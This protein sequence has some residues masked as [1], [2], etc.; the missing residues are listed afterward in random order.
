LEDIP[1]ATVIDPNQITPA[2][3]PASQTSA[4]VAAGGAGVAGTKAPATPGQNVPQQP[5]AQ[6]S[7]YLGA[8]QPQTNQFA[9]Q[10]A[11]DVGGKVNA[12]G[13]AINP[14]VN[15]YTGNL[16]TVPTDTATN[17]AVSTAPSTLTPEQTQSFNTELQAGNNA[18]NSANTFETTSPYQ[19]LTTNIQ[20]AVEQANLWNSG[21]NPANLSTALQPYEAPTATQGDTTLDALLLSG[22]PGAYS[23]IQN[24]VAPAANLQNQLAAGTTQADTSLQNAIAQDQS[25]TAAATAAPQTYANNLTSYLQNAVNQATQGDTAQNAQILQDLQNNTP[26]PADLQTLGVTADQWAT[27]SSQMAADTTAPINLASYLTQT[28]PNATAQNIAT[29]TQYADVAALQNILGGNAPVEPITSATANEAGTALTPSQLNSLNIGQAEIDTQTAPLVAQAQAIISEGNSANAAYNSGD[30]FGGMDP[31]TFNNYI[32]MLNSQLAGI[33]QQLQTIYANNPQFSGQSD[34]SNPSSIVDKTLQNASNT[35]QRI[36]PV[37]SIANYLPIN[38][39]S[40]VA[41]TIGGWFGL[42]E[43]GEVP[44]K[45][46]EAA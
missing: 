29:P 42:S 26:T 15:A 4:P 44:K 24:A 3:Q 1:I 5:S 18:P 13:N 45:F 14:A 2:V 43:G 40:S 41:N 10:I 46:L 27:L 11:S 36:S 8:N 32:N 38:E 34:V 17:Q 22:T 31:G 19:S 7:A 12:A 21:N 39:I 35:A 6:L 37:G 33:N 28:A 20:N 25:T 16:Y 9:G 23:Q 30:H